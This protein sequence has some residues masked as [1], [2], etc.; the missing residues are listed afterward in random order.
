MKHDLIGLFAFI[1]LVIVPVYYIN[2]VLVQKIA[3]RSSFSRFLI[4]MFTGLALAFVYTFIFVWL[5]LKFVYGQ[6]Q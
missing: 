6:H 1:V 3:P 2:R 5:L 4:Y